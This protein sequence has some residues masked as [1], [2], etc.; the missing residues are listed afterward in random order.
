VEYW[1]VIVGVADYPGTIND[2]DYADDDAYDVRDALL[3]SIN[4]EADH[5]TLL[6]DSDATKANI[7]SAIGWMGSNGDA[8]DAFFFFFAGHGTSLDDQYPFDEADGL[9]EALV[10]YDFATAGFV[11]DDEL[12]DWIAAVPGG[13]RMVAIDTCFS[14]GM[15]KAY[16]G[17]RRGLVGAGAPQEGDGFAR[18]LD[19][20]VDGIILTACDDDE[21]SWEIGTLQNGLFTYYFAQGLGGPADANSNDEISMEEIFDYLYPLVTGYPVSPKQYPQECDNWPGEAVLSFFP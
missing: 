8:D 18:D 15:I 7:H 11:S 3:A 13:P 4:W 9:D 19:D 17:Q 12:G 5:I 6:V 20:V 1:A 14:G 16:G 21:G 2:L 10:Q